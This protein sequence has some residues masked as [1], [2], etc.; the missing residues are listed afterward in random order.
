MLSPLVLAT[1]AAMSLGASDFQPH[2]LVK[3]YEGSEVVQ[4]PKVSEFGQVE[5]MLPRPNG[6]GLVAKPLEGQVIQV[7]YRGP[8]ERSAL[9]VF[10]NYQQALERA[11]FQVLVSCIAEQCGGGVRSKVFGYLSARGS[12]Y[13]AARGTQEGREVHVALRV[14]ERQALIVSVQSAGMETDKVQVTAA[15]LQE[16]LEAT[17]HIALY[18]ILFDTGKAELK[19]ESEPVLKEIATLLRGKPSLRLHVV[20]HTDNVGAFDSNLD[21][22]RRRAEAVVKAL[23]ERHSVTA[24]RL[25]PFG[26]ASA[27]PVASNGSEQGRAKNRR[28]ELVEQ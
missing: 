6:K 1:F 11:G 5:L 7:D 8:Q 27:V 3:P 4:K 19:P 20:G 13:L 15:Q 24:A 22:S 18:G 23:V 2:P 16:G 14:F 25:R 21:L 12:H 17:G 28:V 9:E 26:A 10:R